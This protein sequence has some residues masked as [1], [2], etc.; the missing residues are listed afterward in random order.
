MMLDVIE[1]V[2][3]G[4]GGTYASFA[5]DDYLGGTDSC[6]YND[7]FVNVLFALNGQVAHGDDG[8]LRDLIASHVFLFIYLSQVI[9]AGHT[10]CFRGS[11]SQ[12]RLQF[13]PFRFGHGFRIHWNTVVYDITVV[14][15]RV[16]Y[17]T[18]DGG[19]Q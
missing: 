19:G 1:L 13:I 16:G 5:R 12:S 11:V 2:L 9:V 4:E 15:V 8:V 10:A 18:G 3:N 17:D 14:L 6:V 7:F